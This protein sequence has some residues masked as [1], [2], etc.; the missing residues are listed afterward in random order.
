M[1]ITSSSYTTTER[2]IHMHQ[3]YPPHFIPP[4][5]T[6][7]TSIIPSPLYTATEYSVHINYALPTL[8][9]IRVQRSHQLCPPHFILQQ[10]TAFTSIMPSPLY[11]ASEYSVHTLYCNTVQRSQEDAFFIHKHAFPTIL[12]KFICRNMCYCSG[13]RTAIILLNIFLN[14]GWA[15][16][17]VRNFKLELCAYSSKI[18]MSCTSK[19]FLS[20]LTLS[21]LFQRH[22]VR[23]VPVAEVEY[24]FKAR[25]GKF[26]VYGYENKVHSPDYPHTCCWGCC[27]TIM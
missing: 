26:W 11:T 15:R 8:Y 22:Q 12:T 17:I 25:P 1:I 5:S 9:C 10:S 27:C 20:F 14:Q 21:F 4:Q 24:C 16:E 19:L 6:A 7:F 23:I 3:L 18:L 2:S 13:F